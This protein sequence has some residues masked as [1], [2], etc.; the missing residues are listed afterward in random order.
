[1]AK[2]REIIHVDMDAFYA[3]VEQR[4][5]PELRGKAVIVAG[6]AKARGVVSAASY[7]ARGFGIHS[8]MPTAQAIR[9]CPHAIVLPVRMER[10]AEVS[11]QI[12]VIFKRYRPLVKPISPDQAIS[13][14][15]RALRLDS[16]NAL[17]HCKLGVV[18][19]MQ[20]R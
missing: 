5:H 15:R 10:Y 18:L 3:S 8:A 13:L 14:C 2:A 11:R 7:E 1:M 4:D 6:D 12:H 16:D 20:G 9:L 19:G 17:I